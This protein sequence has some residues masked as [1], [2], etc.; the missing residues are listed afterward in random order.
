MDRIRWFE[1][2]RGIILPPADR[3]QSAAVGGEMHGKIGGRRVID[4]FERV[5]A[6]SCLVLEP[7][8]EVHPLAPGKHRIVWYRGDPEP[9]LAI[10]YGDDEIK[11]WEEGPG[12]LELK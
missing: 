1:S 3:I 7:L 5:I 8:G 9:R 6:G 11:I 4:R 2:A 10:D 12:E